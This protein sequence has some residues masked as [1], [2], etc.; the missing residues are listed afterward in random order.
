MCKKVV[1][2]KYTYVCELKYDGVSISLHY[3]NGCLKQ[4][5]TRGDGTQGDDVTSNVRTIKS[6]PLVLQ[7]DTPNEFE[8]RGEIFIPHKGFE[9]MNEDRLES[10]M[11]AFA[12]PRN[13][14]SG[15]L[16]APRLPQLLHHAPLD[17]YLYHSLGDL[18]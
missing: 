2:E 1:S 14:A 16:K 5:L 9:K 8:I 18:I 3:E 6:I 4:A 12:N 11:D 7:G 10:D 13:A 15:T 17:C